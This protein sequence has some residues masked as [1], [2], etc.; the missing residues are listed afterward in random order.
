MRRTEVG[1]I[2]NF[3][4]IRVSS[5]NPTEREERFSPEYVKGLFGRVCACYNGHNGYNERLRWFNQVVYDITYINDIMYN[6]YHISH[7]ML[8][9]SIIKI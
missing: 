5:T 8:C 1:V 9:Q 2:Q 7:N 4:L 3:A 6:L